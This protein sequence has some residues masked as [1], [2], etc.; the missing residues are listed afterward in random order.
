MC[1]GADGTTGACPDGEPLLSQSCR[2]R[3]AG[4]I[5]LLSGVCAL[6]TSVCCLACAFWQ[7]LFAVWC[8]RYGNICLLSGV[9]FLATSVSCP[10]CALWRRRHHRRLPRQCALLPFVLP[11]LLVPSR[12]WLCRPLEVQEILQKSFLSRRPSHSSHARMSAVLTRRLAVFTGV[13]VVCSV[14]FLLSMR[15]RRPDA[16]SSRARCF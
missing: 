6:A 15:L 14:N 16:P 11:F 8:V 5:C 4:N 2:R 9:C 12:V 1:F 10:A 7:H 13:C 3:Q